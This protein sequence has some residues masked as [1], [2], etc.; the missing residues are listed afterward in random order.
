MPHLGKFSRIILVGLLFCTAP[1]RAFRPLPP[2]E[3]LLRML[4]ERGVF[5]F[6]SFGFTESDPNSQNKFEQLTA[7]PEV[8][9]FVAEVNRLLEQLMQKVGEQQTEKERQTMAR[10]AALSRQLIPRPMTLYVSKIDLS[11]DEPVV[12]AG[13]V[14][15]AGDRERAAGLVAQLQA[16]IETSDLDDRLTRKTISGVDGLEIRSADDPVVFVAAQDE[17]FMLTVGEDSLQHLIEQAKSPVPAWLPA[18][19]D[20]LPVDRPALM[21]FVDF[22]QIGK[23]VE[24]SD[25]A[26]AALAWKALGMDH[27]RSKAMVMGLDGEGLLLR[28]LVNCDKMEGLW[29]LFDANGIVRES[30]RAI[31]QGAQSAVCVHFDILEAF[32][33]VVKFASAMEENARSEMDEGLDKVSAQ[34]GMDIRQD[35]LAVFGQNW[36]VYQGNGF[37]A[38]MVPDVLAAVEVRD[39]AKARRLLERLIEVARAGMARQ[40]NSAITIVPAQFAAAEGYTVRGLPMALSF[41]VY[42]GRLVASLSANGMKQFL[43]SA[44][45]DASSIVADQGV[46]ASL[47]RKPDYLVFS[48]SDVA[49]SLTQS[50]PTLQMLLNMGAGRLSEE[51]IDFDPATL[52]RPSVLKK[53]LTSHISSLRRTEDGL[54]WESREVLPHVSISSA[55]GPVMVALLLPAVN[56][57]R[58]AARR[59]ASINNLRQLTLGLLNFESATKR[60]PV[61]GKNGL[62][63]RVHILPYLE[64]QKLHE[65]FHLDEPWDSPHNKSLIEEMPAVFR[66]PSSQAERGR[67]T[68]LAIRGTDPIIA[69]GEN[70]VALAD[71]RDGTS[72][73]IL[74]VAADDDRAVIWTKPDDFDWQAAEPVA[75]LGNLHAGDI[76]LAAFCDGHVQAIPKTVPQE[77]LKALFTKAGEEPVELPAPTR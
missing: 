45:D 14:V 71:I 17:Q 19:M 58:E 44:R 16:A 28:G 53:Y 22:E 11:A 42:D 30:L 70:G 3:V 59:T 31:P 26:K 2:D 36:T 21:A 62:S 67:T 55:G 51:G 40:E 25:D 66:D 48:Y 20:R 63:W 7:D 68:Y 75:G 57:A 76:F 61:A 73:T 8:T 43:S 74:L 6:H 18:L 41:C 46:A 60:F 32:E 64:E 50:Y 24:Q 56:A 49:T 4:P 69:Q 47:D 37:A 39:E 15:H 13:F 23:L 52:P 10:I 27:V 12:E 9:T 29:Q 33:F 1:A 54:E 72:T 5:V 35:V 65:Q 34:L 77:T 38:M